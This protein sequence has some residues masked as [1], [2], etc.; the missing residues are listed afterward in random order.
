M[1]LFMH[2]KL[3]KVRLEGEALQAERIKKG[4]A[5]KTTRIAGKTIDQAPEST[6]SAGVDYEVSRVVLG[7][8]AMMAGLVGLWGFV[9]L[10]SGLI[11]SGGIQGVVTG[12]I[13]AVTGW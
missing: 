12:W 4:D 11:N 10:I 5:M 1:V 3:H 2:R 13:S 6:S 7:V 9:C 8:G